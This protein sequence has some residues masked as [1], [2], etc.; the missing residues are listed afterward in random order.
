MLARLGVRVVCGGLGGVMEGVAR[1]VSDAQGICVGLVP[2]QD[3]AAA[4][5]Y[6][7]VV[8]CTGVGEKRN[9]MVVD[10]SDSVIAIGSN[11]GTVIEALIA[12]KSTTACFG[13]D[14][15]PVVTGGK[16][17]DNMEILDDWAD[18]VT[19]AVEAAQARVRS[20]SRRNC[21]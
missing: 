9:E 11:E 13:L 19:R 20:G 15:H 7:S 6:V 16:R 18:A 8:V 21:G 10:S 17:L 14:F 2:G 3:R 5:Q 12:K 4:N 1:G